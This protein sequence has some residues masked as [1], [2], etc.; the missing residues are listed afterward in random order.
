MIDTPL[1]ALAPA[2]GVLAVG[3]AGAV[4]GAALVMLVTGPLRDRA[5]A[6][7]TLFIVGAGVL[8]LD[9]I[10]FVQSTGQSLQIA[11]IQQNVSLERKWSVHN[12]EA[13]AQG[14]LSVSRQVEQADLI[15]WPE[16]ALPL[17]HDQI[18]P[19]Y[20][21]QLKALQADILLGVLERTRNNDRTEFF[22]SALG[23]GVVDSM[24]RK[25]RLVPFGEF[26]PF[27]PLFSWVLNYLDIPMS[28]FVAW[29]TG[30]L[31]MRLAG[32]PVGVSIC[33]EN[34]FG[35]SLSNLQIRYT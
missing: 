22:N 17:Y 27:R 5:L 13:I 24:Y 4:C 31:P 19:A 20:L 18:S 2:G 9:R 3:A 1:A 33:Y 14:Y 34:E 23:L 16:A 10:E 6:V 12:R 25:Q 21:T 8:V 7:C 28:E 29:P 30:Q 26:L 32:Q 15:V 35:C 11:I